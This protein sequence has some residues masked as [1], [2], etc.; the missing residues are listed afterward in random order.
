MGVLDGLFAV[1]DAGSFS[2]DT[3][4]SRFVPDRAVL[5]TGT[6]IEV[7]SVVAGEFLAFLVTVVPTC[8]LWGVRL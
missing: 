2:S 6:G 5:A 3:D 1:R 7:G 8:G 4:R